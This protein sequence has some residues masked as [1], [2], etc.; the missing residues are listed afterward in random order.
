MDGRTYGMDGPN[1]DVDRLN[2]SMD[3]STYSFSLHFFFRVWLLR[4]LGGFRRLASAKP[5]RQ[6]KCRRTAYHYRL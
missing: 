4:L 2:Y 3:G 6:K 5:K 1:Y